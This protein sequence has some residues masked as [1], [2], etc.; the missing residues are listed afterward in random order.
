MI[1]P[2][3]ET[4]AANGLVV[5]PAELKLHQALATA[6]PAG[7][8]A[9]HSLKIRIKG[10]AFAESDF[11]IADPARGILGLEVKGGLVRKK[12]G[13]WLQNAHPMKS[14]PLDQAH[15]FARILLK[16][17]RDRGLVP[18][19][20]GVAVA[21][22]DTE[23]ASQPTQGD[24]EGLVMGARD[25]PYLD[26][27]L[28]ALMDRAL[29]ANGRRTPPTPDWVAF[30]HQLWDES[31]PGAMRLSTVIKGREAGR[32]RL[33][34][35]QFQALE[36]ALE[37]DFVLVQ[38][39]AGTGKTFLVRE[40]ARREAAQG[41]RVLVL[42]FTE[43]LGMELAAELGTD[44]GASGGRGAADGAVT[45][46]PI[47]KFALDRLRRVGFNEAERCEPLFWDRVTGMAAEND[48]LWKDG[49]FDTVIVDEGQDLGK[50]EWAIAMRS[51]NR[52]RGRGRGRRMWIFADECQTFWEKRRVPAY[53][54]RRAVKYSL[55][56]PYRCPPGIQALA[57]AYVRE[58]GSTG[59]GGAV[60]GAVGGVG[61]PGGGADVSEAIAKALADGTVKIVACGD[62]E[63]DLHEAVG[64][65]LRTLRRKDGFAEGDI[66]V[67]S[68]RGM[69]Y[70]G[71][72]M[73]QATLGGYALAQAMDPERR[74]RIVCDT[75]LRYKGLERPVVVVADVD[76]A[77]SRYPV[78][79]NIAV[80]RAFGAL[81]VVASR[82]ELAK[83][84]V[85]SKWGT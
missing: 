14:P 17:F 62:T 9:W 37:N 39:R 61:D 74:E 20:V 81:R 48:E 28:P 77:V 53:V 40:L 54:E 2:P 75:F 45:V 70:P 3:P 6:L 51:A 84:P 41:R 13:V 64:S 22:P 59:A 30:L 15:R 71:N 56:R 31:W 42:T 67:L 24:L 23:F 60:G 55:G 8:T 12:K 50:N 72:I 16:K 79:M 43:A 85:L 68:L 52:G 80:S 73:R 58:S 25:V 46:S 33:D 69:M 19:P 11:V 34:A 65:E 36:G 1:Y 57:D 7:W 44:L 26:E 32:V 66:A 47:W 82:R 5:P 49:G 76:T 83:D 38:G 35:E 18:P 10:G 27:L 4:Y 29:P 78:R 63:A 21:F